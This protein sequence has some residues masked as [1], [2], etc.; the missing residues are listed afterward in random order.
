MRINSVL[1]VA[2]VL[3]VQTMLMPPPTSAEGQEQKIKWADNFDQAL[4]LAQAQK[5]PIL[6]DFFNPN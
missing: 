1:M 4:S 2:V 3:V 6:L 5:K